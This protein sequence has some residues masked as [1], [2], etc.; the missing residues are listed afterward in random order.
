MF[1]NPSNEDSRQWQVGGWIGTDDTS[2]DVGS[3]TPPLS[4]VTSLSLGELTL[5]DWIT[6]NPITSAGLD[7]VTSLPS[8]KVVFVSYK[9]GQE[10]GFMTSPIAR[11]EMKR[12]SYEAY[13][14][15]TPY[16]IEI[17]L[18][19]V[20]GS[21]DSLQLKVDQPLWQSRSGSRASIFTIKAHGVD[22]VTRRLN[23]VADFISQ[24]NTLSGQ[25]NNGIFYSALDPVSAGKFYIIA[26]PPDAYYFGYVG[27]II[28]RIMV[29][30]QAL[31]RAATNTKLT[32]WD[33]GTY[34]Q[35]TYAGG[36]FAAG[37]WSG[38][39]YTVTDIVGGTG[40]PGL[41]VG[42]PKLVRHFRNHDAGYTGYSNTA[43]EFRPNYVDPVDDTETY[44]MFT[45]EVGKVQ[46]DRPSHAYRNISMKLAVTTSTA[47]DFKTFMD[48]FI[49]NFV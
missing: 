20:L 48:T 12:L 6:R 17:T 16:A 3:I 35:G 24:I 29:G 19:S 7:S 30:E 39:T 5:I 26:N 9:D 46:S 49:L 43:G 40:V 21:G 44:D 11:G 47:A 41:G 25:G 4:P 15:Y 28:N 31:Y 37:L 23:A 45:L 22:N 34:T 2:Y 14:D 27:V 18:P 33:D 36:T 1:F 38:G 42:V 10:Q 32:N 8:N 13:E